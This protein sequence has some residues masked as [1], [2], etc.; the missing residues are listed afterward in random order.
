M[1]IF[2]TRVFLA[3][4]LALAAASL[5]MGR[6]GRCAFALTY[7]LSMVF[8]FVF[9]GMEWGSYGF[10]QVV[11]DITTARIA[12][13]YSETNRNL[14]KLAKMNICFIEVD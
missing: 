8:Y 12:W 10:E 7:G 1:L 6:W 11:K 14:H 2:V 5:L 4:A 13:V 9:L 3:P